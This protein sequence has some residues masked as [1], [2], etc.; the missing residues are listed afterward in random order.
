[1]HV[2]VGLDREEE[3]DRSLKLPFLSYNKRERV[4]MGTS[5]NSTQHNRRQ[6][7]I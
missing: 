4:C 1:M 5:N 2:R 6:Y 7:N 3:R